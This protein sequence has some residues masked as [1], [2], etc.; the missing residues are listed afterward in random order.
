MFFQGKISLLRLGLLA[1]ALS[2]R[3][4]ELNLL[5]ET[6]PPTVRSHSEDFKHKEQAFKET[7]HLFNTILT[8][9][10]SWLITGKS[11][12]ETLVFA[13]TNPQYDDRLFIELQAQYIKIPNSNL[14]RTCCVPKLFL[15]FRTFFAHNMFSPCSAKKRVS[16][17]DLPVKPIFFCLQLLTDTYLRLFP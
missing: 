7:R 16:D 14:Q 15:T 4:K 17:K 1:P 6:W 9:F 10:F 8:L 5:L 11:L 13:S 2:S 3:L 12:S